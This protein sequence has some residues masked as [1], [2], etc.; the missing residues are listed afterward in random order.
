MRPQTIPL[1][2]TGTSSLGEFQ[3]AF[4]SALFEPDAEAARPSSVAALIAQP[5]FA[6]YRNTVVRASIDAL[7][8]NYPTVARLVG[9]E[10]FRAAASLFV[11]AHPPSQPALVTYGAKFAT[12]LEGFA[13]AAEL[14]Y[15]PGVARVDRFWT[16]AHVA[17]DAPRLRAIPDAGRDESLTLRPHPAARWAWFE[18]GPLYTIWHRNRMAGPLDDRDFAWCGEGVLVVRP[19]DAVRWLQLD[20]GACALLDACAEGC[21]LE[22]ACTAAAAVAPTIDCTAVLLR[23]LDAGAFMQAA[24]VDRPHEA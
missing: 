5:G 2:S 7:E 14:P 16:E 4:A 15:L 23:L 12:F 21:D 6:V 9:S 1:S 17:S 22:A 8:A 20:A 3:D 11:R 10:W 13:P 18:D 24:I 19:D